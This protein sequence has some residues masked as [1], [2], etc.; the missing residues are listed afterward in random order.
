MSN[1]VLV[2]GDYQMTGVDSF[3]WWQ[4][5][6][7]ISDYKTIILDTN[8]IFTSW[9]STSRLKKISDVHYV[10]NDINKNDIIIQSNLKLIKNK[11]VEMLFFDVEIYALFAPTIRIDKKMGSIDILANSDSPPKPNRPRHIK[12]TTEFVCTND[13]CPISIE[14][15]SEKGKTIIIKDNSYQDYFKE[16]KEWRHYFIPDSIT[17]ESL[18][19]YYDKN[20]K[21]IGQIIPISANTVDK[22]LAVE[23]FPCFH[24]LFLDEEGL[25]WSSTP[26]E[27]GGLLTM[28]PVINEY[29]TKS[30]IKS[31][32]K[33][34]GVLE[35]SPPPEWVDSVVIPGEDSLNQEIREEQK[36]LE[37]ITLTIKQKEC[38][39]SE[40]QQ[41]KGLLFETG[42]PLQELVRTTL[43]KLGAKIE[44]SLVTDEFIINISGKR[45]LIEVKGNNKSISKSDIAQLNIDMDVHL[46]K[47]NENIGGILIGNGWRLLPVE[48]RNTPDKPI[49][50]NNVVEIA[51][52]SNIGL[53]STIDLYR[54]FC[55]VLK[56][57]SCKGDVLNKVISCIPS[58][59]I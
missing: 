47:T 29:D 27:Y 52:A 14:T 57:S 44:P 4:E 17:I 28:L 35:K 49:F 23:F 7:N 20:W 30:H 22:P 18:E 38:T 6:P 10:L 2:I 26:D 16:F 31:L 3:K 8:Q 53:L 51:K 19:S 21:T 36:E 58:E 59:S 32:L 50:P 5:L 13:W 54:V 40:I 45:A 37:K 9:A 1:N 33:K 41:Y 24:K 12:Q 15:R 56:D 48:E 11:L 43:E 25:R 34:I 46:K 42:I 55:Q 39:L